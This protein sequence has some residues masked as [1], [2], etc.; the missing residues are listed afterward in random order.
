M[1]N[2]KTLIISLLI[3]L[4]LYGGWLRLSNIGS[5]SL[6]IDEAFSIQAAQAILENGEPRF[7]TGAFYKNHFLNSYLLAGALKIFPSFDAFNPWQVRIPALIFGTFLI[8]LFY[9]FIFTLTKRHSLA[10]VSAG[11]L[12]FNTVEIAWSRQARGYMAEQFFIILS[13]LFLWWYVKKEKIYYGIGSAF[14]I[15]LAIAFHLLS[16][17]FLPGIAL[18][19]L[20]KNFKRKSVSIK[21]FFILLTL[22]PVI[23]YAISLKIPTF[24]SVVYYSEYFFLH[25]P[26]VTILALMGIS[27]VFIKK[28]ILINLF[29]SNIFILIH[30]VMPLIAFL[31][32]AP[33][34]HTRYVLLIMPFLLYFG[35]LA[36]YTLVK[37]LL[38]NIN[39]KWLTSSA[40]VLISVIVFTN[41]ITIFP[42]Q[43][44]QLGYDSPQPNFKKAYEV[45]KEDLTEKDVLITAYPYMTELFLNQS[46]L[47]VPFSISGHANESEWV[48]VDGKERVTGAHVVVDFSELDNILNT[49]QGFILIDQ[50]MLRR[51]PDISHFIDAHPNT[52]LFHHNIE[53]N[54]AIWVFKYGQN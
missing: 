34:A 21:D 43:S 32:T 29:N 8:P 51:V 47:W 28:D 52:E 41:H 3:L 46:G 53:P 20:W 15:T 38:K 27:V 13:L 31:F 1:K 42:K 12:A 6:W 19:L 5:Q 35:V 11:L 18:V 40:L 48:I 22:S 14:F 36:I 54:G 2:Q 9:I 10:L 45:I 23:L 4:T 7:E 16:I 24:I 44:Y 33:I 49:K 39:N 37:Y 50:L 26:I 30:T 17:V 25:I